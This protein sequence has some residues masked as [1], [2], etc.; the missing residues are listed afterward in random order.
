MTATLEHVESQEMGSDEIAFRDY[1]NERLKA[2]GL[3]AYFSYVRRKKDGGY[4][5]N[6]ID[7]VDDERYLDVFDDLTM[8]GWYRFLSEKRVAFTE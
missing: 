4:D 3:D 1:L 8:S 6:L 2:R 5:F 7:N